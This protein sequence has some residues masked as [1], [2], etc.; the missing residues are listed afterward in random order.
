MA[1]STVVRWVRALSVL[2][3][4]VATVGDGISPFL[5]FGALFVYMATSTPYAARG[6]STVGPDV[7]KLLAVKTLR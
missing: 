3:I 7:T 1:V 6:L 4:A 2:Q 5:C